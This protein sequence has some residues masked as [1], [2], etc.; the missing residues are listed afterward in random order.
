M[1]NHTNP[2]T[3]SIKRNCSSGWSYCDGI[4]EPCYPNHLRCSFQR[5]VFGDSLHCPNTE[6]LKHC[7]QFECPK[8]FKCRSSHCI[9]FHMVCDGVVDCPH[10]EDEMKCGHLSC[11]GLL[12]CV[13]DK[14]CVH[15]NHICDGIIHCKVSMDDELFCDSKPCPSGCQCVGYSIVCSNTSLDTLQSLAKNT[16]A[17]IFQDVKFMPTGLNGFVD[18][19]YLSLKNCSINNADHKLYPYKNLTKLIYLDISW[20]KFQYIQKNI[21][22]DVNDLEFINLEGNTLSVIYSFG[23][24]G[25]HAVKTLS[26]RRT[27]VKIIQ[28]CAFCNIQQLQILDLSQNHLTAL[29]DIGLRTLPNLHTLNITYNTIIDMYNEIFIDLLKLELILTTTPAV[30]CYAQRT[31]NCS[32]TS[33]NISM[34]TSCNNLMFDRIIFVIT[35]LNIV[36]MTFVIMFT[37]IYYMR[38]KSSKVHF[39]LI[40]HLSLSDIGLALYLIAICYNAMVYGTDFE[41]KRHLWQKSLTCKILSCLFI[42]PLLVSQYTS[43]LISVNTLLLTKYALTMVN[44]SGKQL[45]ALL[46]IGWAASCAIATPFVNLADNQSPMCVYSYEVN[47]FITVKIVIASLCISMMIAT[48]SIHYC[49]LKHITE[50]SKR[51]RKSKAT[52]TKSIKLKFVSISIVNLITIISISLLLNAHLLDEKTVSYLIVGVLPCKTYANLLIYIV[53]GSGSRKMFCKKK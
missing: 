53:F 25:L 19:L 48:S 23:F 36:F 5:D 21:F 3:D 43:C 44:I 45:V 27:F 2:V 40:Q 18:L 29:P 50:S 39:S 35:W 42:V 10:S 4:T 17:I 30:C 38:L 11:P 32:A 47:S 20:N 49:V 41:M 33:H 1:T 12:K 51:I 8:M 46:G 6:H 37:V 15:P 52:D 24:Q 9:S 26:L 28:K 13:E 7:L 22:N 31:S 14:L 16:Y 34:T